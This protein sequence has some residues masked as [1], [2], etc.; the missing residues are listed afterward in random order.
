M[1]QA[2]MTFPE[3]APDRPPPPLF[4]IG[5]EGKTLAEF[6]GELAAAKV[7][8]VIDVR[9]IAASRR[10]GFSKTA[11]S[12][13]LREAGIDYLHLRTLG[14]PKAG[15]DAARRGRTLEM[16]KMYAVQLATPEAELALAQLEAAALQRP[17]ALLCYEA[18][19]GG[20]HRAVIAERLT[21]FRIIDL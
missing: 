3:P 7:S 6:L 11:L 2:D 20:C 9:A 16:R 13:A 14:T 10:P 1:S 18:Q 5:Y 12:G 17:S 8:L 21:D 15:R 4:T 19:A